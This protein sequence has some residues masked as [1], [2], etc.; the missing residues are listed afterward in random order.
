MKYEE[1]YFIPFKFSEGQA[2]RHLE[3]AE[4][5]MGIARKDDILDVKFNYAYTAL[6]K[7]GIALL[8]HN[9]MKIRSIPGHHAIIIEYIAN[10]IGEHEI[11]AVG[12]AMRS[13]RNVGMYSGGTEVTEKECHEYIDFVEKIVAKVKEKLL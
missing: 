13:K 8:A 7:S 2:L 9:G 1:K 10:T 3:N 12:N 5:D 11:D 6:I 4:K